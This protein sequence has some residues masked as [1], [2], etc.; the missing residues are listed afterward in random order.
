MARLLYVEASPRKQRSASIEVARAF[1]AAYREAHPADEIETLDL[2]AVDL[3]EFDGAAMEAK[4]AGL[5]GTSLTEGQEA[6]WRRIRA[7]AQPF[8]AADKLLFA[9]PLWNFGIPY[10]L[11]HLIDAISQKDVLF[12]FTDQGFSG[13]LQGRKA[14][15]IYARGLDYGASAFTPAAGFDFQKPYMEM[16]LRFIGITDVTAVTVEKTLFGPEV[17][18]QARAEAKSRAESVAKTF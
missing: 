12:S 5:S 8:H 13:L 15:V 9:V 1:L 16:W 3:P 18:T 6:A 7:L 17:D 14:A 2:W 10:K 4:Y 11:K